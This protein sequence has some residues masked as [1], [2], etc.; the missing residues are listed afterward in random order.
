MYLAW[1]RDGV[2]EDVD[3]LTV[4]H[5]EGAF[6][7]TLLCVSVQLLE[8]TASTAKCDVVDAPLLVHKA[9][10]DH[11]EGFVVDSVTPDH[12]DVRVQHLVALVVHG[13]AK[14][15]GKDGEQLQRGLAGV[16]RVRPHHEGAFPLQDLVLQTLAPELAARLEHVV[17]VAHAR[18]NAGGV[19]L[20]HVLEGVALTFSAPCGDGGVL[21]GG[22]GVSGADALFR[23]DGCL[24]EGGRG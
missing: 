14:A 11:L 6:E 19:R 22:D 2:L 1:V 10:R 8:K 20:Q 7:R 21:R 17:A 5:C 18:H 3:A 9:C 15:F 16:A 4:D 13:V 24:M 12:A 23:V